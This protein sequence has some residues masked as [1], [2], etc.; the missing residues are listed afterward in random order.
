MTVCSV[1]CHQSITPTAGPV[2][3][4]SF[5]FA[6]ACTACCVHQAGSVS[7]LDEGSLT[8]SGQEITP[9][10][11]TYDTHPSFQ[12]PPNFRLRKNVSG[13]DLCTLPAKSFLKITS[14]L[15]DSTNSWLIMPRP[16]QARPELPCSVE[17]AQCMRCHYVWHRPCT[18][19]WSTHAMHILAST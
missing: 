9:D 8:C 19:Q 2:V 6:L 4:C 16:G 1:V 3:L 15:A 18:E 12:L 5:Y 10:S 13:D 11:Q 14:P 17:A 7:R